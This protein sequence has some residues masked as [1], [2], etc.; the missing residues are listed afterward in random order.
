M[1]K[2]ENSS[3]SHLSNG[4]EVLYYNTIIHNPILYK[5][6]TLKT[7]FFVFH[8]IIYKWNI[9]YFIVTI[10]RTR[11]LFDGVNFFIYFLNYV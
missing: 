9:F 2:F 10:D 1:R 7:Y 5:V 3:R 4:I 6:M 8:I 11:W